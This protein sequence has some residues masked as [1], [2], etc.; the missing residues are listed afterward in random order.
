MRESVAPESESSATIARPQVKGSIIRAL[1]AVLGDRHLLS[2]VGERLSPAARAL[3]LD[4]P[5]QTMWIDAGLGIEIYQAILETAGPEQLRAISRESINRGLLPL[6]R[7]TI[8]RVLAIFGASPAILLARLDRAAA[9]TSR[10]MVYRYTPI[11]ESSGDFDMEIPGLTD[12]PL[13]PFV[14]TAGALELIFEMC[15][16]R[17]AFSEPEMVPNGKNNRMRYRVA[18]RPVTRR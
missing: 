12:V 14:S 11:D 4:P 6:L 5:L 8:E 9:G 10:G 2:V 17:G 16:A 1:V 13:G 7:A 15:G 3:L 18:W